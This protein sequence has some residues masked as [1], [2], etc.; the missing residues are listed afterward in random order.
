MRVTKTLGLS[1][2]ISISLFKSPLSGEPYYPCYRHITSYLS[3]SSEQI[4]PAIQTTLRSLTSTNSF[5]VD[6]LRGLGRNEHLEHVV[7]PV[8]DIEES[9]EE[10]K[11]A[12]AVLVDL[13]SLDL[14]ALFDSSH[15]LGCHDSWVVLSGRGS[16]LVLLREK[17]AK[18]NDKYVEALQRRTKNIING[19]YGLA[20]FEAVYE[21]RRD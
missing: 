19:P 5:L 17:E 15:E 3:T 10:G 7:A 8:E 12:A 6:T 21:S 1:S 16:S 13:S 11:E 14:V 20:L 9:E 4:T 2:P 18:V